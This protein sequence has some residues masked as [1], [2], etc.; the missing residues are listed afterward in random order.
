MKYHSFY[1]PV[2]LAGALIGLALAEIPLVGNKG[3]L[4]SAH[5]VSHILLLLVTAP[6]FVLALAAGR[7]GNDRG[8]ALSRHLTAVPWLNWLAG[9]GILW[10]WH[11]PGF[12]NS[13]LAA[14]VQAGNGHIHL[15]PALHTGSVLIAGVLFCWPLAGPF[16]SHR[17]APPEATLYL[18][19]AFVACLLLGL[20]ISGARP[21]LYH[22][23]PLDSQL[24][25]MI[26]LVPCSLLY[27]ASI[28]YLLREWMGKE[29]WQ[30][31]D[32]SRIN[33][34]RRKRKAETL[35][36]ADESTPYSHSLIRSKRSFG[37]GVIITQVGIIGPS[38][39]GSTGEEDFAGESPR[40]VEGSFSAEGIFAEAPMS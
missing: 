32:F 11:I 37:N 24:A 40:A 23:A 30:P 26:V 33:R 28:V 15:L 1:R 5:M 35:G 25:G 38:D 39:V 9:V 22:A 6:L 21:G 12:L 3:A 10:F 2:C 29:I 4:F 16:P 27:L 20:L 17:L 7:S 14:E 36:Q 31:N 19:T 18:T 8:I 13:L 34:F